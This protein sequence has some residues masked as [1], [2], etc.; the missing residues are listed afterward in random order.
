VVA[1]AA[2]QRP[3]TN[4]RCHELSIVPGKVKVRSIVPVVNLTKTIMPCLGETLCVGP[5]G[6]PRQV[7]EAGLPADTGSTADRVDLLNEKCMRSKRR[8]L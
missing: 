3:A 4:I 5:G 7:Q 8:H 6:R 1:N 2:A